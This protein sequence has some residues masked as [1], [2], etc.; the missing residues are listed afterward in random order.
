MSRDPG[1]KGYL[2]GGDRAHHVCILYFKRLLLL[3]YSLYIPSPIGVKNNKIIK[4]MAL[5]YKALYQQT[6]LQ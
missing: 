3:D 2:K 6:T 1:N 4:C 5:I